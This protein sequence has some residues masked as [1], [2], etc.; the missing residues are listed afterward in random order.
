MKSLK[1][2]VAVLLVAFAFYNFYETSAGQKRTEAPAPAGVQEAAPEALPE[3]AGMKHV[4]NSVPAVSS[5]AVG[6]AIKEKTDKITEEFLAVETGAAEITLE[7]SADIKESPEYTTC[8]LSSGTDGSMK[9]ERLFYRNSDGAEVKA[10]DILGEDYRLWFAD[11][12][13]YSL[14]EHPEDFPGKLQEDYGSYIGSGSELFNNIYLTEEGVFL[15]VPEK[16]LFEKA[17]D[18]VM[19]EN[20]INGEFYNERKIY[21]TRPMVALTFD[22]GPGADSSI[23]ILDTLKE[24]NAKATFF[25]IAC[26]AEAHPETAKRAS[27]EGHLIGSHTWQHWRIS[28]RDSAFLESDKEECDRIFNQVLGYIPHIMRPPE[29]LCDSTAVSFYEEPLMGW[30]IDPL[31]WYSKDTEDII[32]TVKKYE[33]LDGQVILLHEIYDS[34]AEAVKVLVPWLVEQGYQLVTVDELFKYYYDFDPAGHYFYTSEFFKLGKD[35][36]SLAGLK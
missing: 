19:P 13:E 22:D 26:N 6:N 10:E 2:I 3:N 14:A 23:A 9:T 27:D 33:N 7:I 25:E 35:A 28:E 31:D 15:S 8:L 1:V 24:Y 4:S 5:A 18:L 17:E 21:K 11:Y 34:T 20:V 12:F 32:K 36:A 16:T 30:S 29:G